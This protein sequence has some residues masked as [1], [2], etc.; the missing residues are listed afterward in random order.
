MEKL[1]YVLPVLVLLLLISCVSTKASTE[2][3][4]N[5]LFDSDRVHEINIEIKEEEWQDLLANPVDKTKYEVSVTIDGELF[6]HVS[7]STTGNSSLTHVASTDSDRYSFKLNFTKHEKGRTYHGLD[8]MK[9]SNLYH[10]PTCMED[11]ISYRIITEAGGYAPLASYVWLKINGEDYGLYLCVEEIDNGY[12]DRTQEGQGFLYKP[13]PKWMDQSI[14]VPETT[15][16]PD[17]VLAK[18]ENRRAYFGSTDFGADLVYTDDRTESY[19]A[20]FD[21]A[22]N[23]SKEEDDIRLIEILRKLNSKEDLSSV[24][25]TSEIIG[26]FAG[27]NFTLSYDSYMGLPV[28]NYFILEKNGVLSVVA[29][30]YNDAFGDLLSRIYP[31]MTEDEI[32]SW[33]IDSPLFGVEIS[34]RP[35]WSW[36]ADSPEYLEEYHAAL[37]SLL[38]NY[39]ESGRAQEEMERVYNLIRPYVSEDSTFFNTVEEF[40]EGY[41]DLVDFCLKRTESIRSQLS[42]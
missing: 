7:M 8:K 40:E 39:F 24:L 33:D 30:D 35:L 34:D 32:I 38:E 9:L 28:Q 18:F 17:N 21:E 27:H 31:Q 25:N 11:Y 41:S 19:S 15:S 20:I 26:Y 6:D 22:V 1:K 2:K 14:K 5:G 36:I 23:N 16:D 29:W 10:D 12:L 4:Y 37:N 3:E 13:E 42:V